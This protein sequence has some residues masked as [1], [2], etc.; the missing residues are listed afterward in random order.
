M[1]IVYPNFFRLI[2]L[3]KLLNDGNTLYRRE[4]Y[5]DAAHRY[6]YAVRRVPD[7]AING[8]ED[9]KETFEQLKLHLLLNLSRCSRK[10]G[11]MSEAIL[12]A[13]SILKIKPDCLEALKSRATAL[14]ESGRF[15][16]A[17]H[18]LNEALKQSPQNRDLMKLILKIKD[19]MNHQKLRF[20][21]NNEVDAAAEEQ[22]IIGASNLKY[23]D[24]SA[25]DF[26]SVAN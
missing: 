18:D 2:L 5:E 22:P 13:T 17:I 8:M 10:R 20:L 3:N 6:Q 1:V 12:H 9:F 15:N 4:K 7:A 26:G 19:E 16:E 25:S 23:A 24:D 21:N 14:K 11:Q